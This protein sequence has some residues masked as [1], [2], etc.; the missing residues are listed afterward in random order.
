MEKTTISPKLR[1]RN[2]DREAKSRLRARRKMR[3]IRAGLTENDIKELE[4][5]EHVRTILCLSYGTH[6]VQN[7]TRKCKKDKKEIEVPNILHG[8]A[9]IVFT[10]K[11]HNIDVLTSGKQYVYVKTT[12]D[13][14]DEISKIMSP[15][16]RIYVQEW[17]PI[18][19]PNPMKH[20][21]KKKSAPTMTKAEVKAYYAA[22]RKGGVSK[23]IKKYNPTLADKITNLIKNKKKNKQ[24]TSFEKKAAKKAAKKAKIIA[25]NLKVAERNAKKAE[26]NAKKP[27]K[28][29]K[30]VETKLK[31]AA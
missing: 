31:M 11:Q 5:N 26:I 23:R 21:T 4:K 8:T 30:P 19:A 20:K 12:D 13:K 16:G 17:H 24:V 22:L 29:K 27:Q 15:M 28:S 2:I 14:V 3:L 1:A 6:T 9:A 18:V 25:T 10:L 7:G